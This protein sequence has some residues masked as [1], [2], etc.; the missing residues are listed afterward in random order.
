MDTEIYDIDGKLVGHEK[1][2]KREPR[3]KSDEH[4]P[5][6]RKQRQPR[7]SRMVE[8]SHNNLTV[9]VKKAEVVARMKSI[10]E[11]WFDLRMETGDRVSDG[12]LDS[13]TM[14]WA[15]KLFVGRF[16]SWI[17]KGQ[18]GLIYDARVDDGLRFRIIFEYDCESGYMIEEIGPE[19]LSYMTTFQRTWA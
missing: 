1:R 6:L 2:Q 4:K 9:W 18:Y 10:M 15:E 8:Y 16:G 12:M 3:M 7:T 17:R 14:F 19:Q 5:R 11:V 13:A